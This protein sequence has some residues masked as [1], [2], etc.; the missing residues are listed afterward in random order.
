[1]ILKPAECCD[2]YLKQAFS[3]LTRIGVAPKFGTA[4]IGY[5]QERQCN[6]LKFLEKAIGPFEVRC[7]KG[8]FNLKQ[9]ENGEIL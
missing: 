8:R 4:P 5:Y 7:K 1:M 3:W 2:S 9:L 6:A